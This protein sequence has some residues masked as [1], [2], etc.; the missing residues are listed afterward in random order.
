MAAKKT[1]K[2]SVTA[3]AKKS[4]APEAE[5]PLLETV[6]K[7]HGAAMNVIAQCL[8][9]LA[10]AAEKR[11][12]LLEG[13]GSGEDLGA[14]DLADV[15]TRL[16][17]LEAFGLAS[18]R[19][20][21]E[22]VEVK[23]TP[24]AAAAP[25]APAP[26]AAASD[27]VVTEIA[28]VVKRGRGRPRNPAKCAHEEVV[29]GR[30]M[31][32]NTT[33]AERAAQGIVAKPVEQQVREAAVALA[34]PPEVLR[35]PAEVQEVKAAGAAVAAVEKPPVQAAAIDTSEDAIKAF[36]EGNPGCKMSDVIR[37]T[38]CSFNR[39]EAALALWGKPAVEKAPEKTYVK[40][41]PCGGCGVD[42][43]GNEP[44][45][46]ACP[47][48]KKPEPAAQKTV[49]AVAEIKALEE[50]KTPLTIDDVKA[51]AI[52]FA[53]AHGREKLG[54]I[55]RKYGPGNLSGLPTDS[56]AAVMLDLANGSAS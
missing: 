53:S 42:L 55:L 7:V 9:D 11:N 43:D 46:A 51:V 48:Q 31:K 50:K 33:E 27:A 35:T 15:I 14:N 19:A 22:K 40:P 8:R 49:D 17:K 6:L 25:V 18:M 23:P 5:T 3:V 56:Y 12:E 44:H 45:S 26:A 30:C 32:C 29:E 13:A 10:A 36:V 2:P 28:A 52:T 20:N 47:T 34:V 41:R 24:V 16:D 39:A 38:K 37:A 1:K 4:K 54:T 21:A